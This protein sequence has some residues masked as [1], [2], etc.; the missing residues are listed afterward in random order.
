MFHKRSHNVVIVYNFEIT[1]SYRK[2]LFYTLYLMK[3]SVLLCFQD[4]GIV[5]IGLLVHPSLNND[6][7]V[8]LIKLM[9]V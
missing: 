9:I 3:I 6:L 8:E 1:T 5:L 4:T 2:W 7:T